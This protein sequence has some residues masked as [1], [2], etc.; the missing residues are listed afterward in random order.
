MDDYDNDVQEHTDLVDVSDVSTQFEEMAPSRRRRPS[1]N[2]DDLDD[3]AMQEPTMEAARPRG[4]VI[5]PFRDRLAAFMIDCALLYVMYW[6]L[7]IGYRT[8]AFEVA[9]GPIPVAGIHGLIFHGLF[10]LIAFLYYLLFESTVL[11][12]PG[13]L[14]C[15][16]R[17]RRSDGGM[18]SI[19]ALIVRNLLR[20]LDIVLMPVI[21][22]LACMEWT[23]RHQR[24]GDLLGG[25]M[26]IRTHATGR[27]EFS[28]ASLPTATG[29]LCAFVIDALLFLVF[30]A[31]YA[32]VLTP[33]S[34]LFSMF[35]VVL[36]P[37]AACLFFML[38]LTLLATSPGKWL[39]GYA[40]GEEDGTRIGIAAAFLRTA[41]LLF[42]CTPL[43]YG[44]MLCSS[45]HQRPGDVI[46]QSMVYHAPRAWKT[47]IGFALLITVVLALGYAGISNRANF[48][49]DSFQVN[50][51]PAVTRGPT[52]APTGAKGILAIASFQ[53]AAGRP[54]DTRTPAVFQPGEKVY[55]VFSVNG[56]A[57]K[58]D[59][60]W[61]Q[62]DLNVRYP[63]G[64]TGLKLENII[65]FHEGLEQPG[66]IEMTNNI[67][68]PMD[69]MPGRYT[70]SIVLRDQN[71]GRQM[72]EQRFFYVAP[73][74]ALPEGTQPPTPPSPAS[75]PPGVPN[76]APEPQ[77]SS[78]T[79]ASPM[80]SPSMT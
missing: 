43:G 53:F 75:P 30:V 51:L 33:E 4:L 58:N 48:L 70:V 25:T 26:L 63:D 62:E 1:A 22:P 35:L 8:I 57:V 6:V 17:V 54:E 36:F 55:L 49:S 67:A 52:V 64:S 56:G 28:A 80:A 69:A 9:A 34:P 44:V 15:R 12:T 65:D 37:L 59:K 27:R 73:K 2:E 78:P 47:L 42:D 31:G 5:A 24:I 79:P 14:F 61:I 39:F 46:A 68:L 20:P 50:F 19:V 71:S 45:R 18:P 11:A 77:P 29:R 38:P 66:P 40:V 3:D 74:S 16:L 7:L 10:M 23:S 76:T 13:K 21:L 72:N 32:L 60:Y 41:A